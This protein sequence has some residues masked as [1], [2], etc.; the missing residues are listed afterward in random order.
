M[1]KKEQIME[2]LTNFQNKQNITAS[3]V[4]VFLEQLGVDKTI[5]DNLGTL[6]LGIDFPNFIKALNHP[7]TKIEVDDK[8]KVTLST[9]YGNAYL[10]NEN[11]Q[12]SPIQVEMIIENGNVDLT[13]SYDSKT[14]EN[15]VMKKRATN[16]EICTSQFGDEKTAKSRRSE[17]ALSQTFDYQENR[18][19]YHGDAVITSV[20][21]SAKRGQISRNDISMS[22]D[23]DLHALSNGNLQEQ[24]RYL[25]FQAGMRG[26]SSD[27]LQSAIIN[28]NTL[29]ARAFALWERIV[30]RGN[31]L[32]NI[33]L[34]KS[35]GQE[36]WET[37]FTTP[38]YGE[39]NMASL[40]NNSSS[41]ATEEEA[42][43]QYKTGLDNGFIDYKIEEYRK[44]GTENGEFFAA[45]IEQLKETLS[46]S[47]SL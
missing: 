13:T 2:A 3:D 47:K 32:T 33:V 10:V 19:K 26:L 8:G 27:N 12:V 41:Y 43:E 23:P 30:R 42:L 1:D 5:I 38:L 11:R 16:F 46:N 28:W 34:F 45:E 22:N 21:S 29:G 35:K 20:E 17:Y 36:A 44:L 31:N 4:K 18:R 14:Y 40:L 6:E 25:K 7:L 9:E 15:N 37:K 24:L 39:Y